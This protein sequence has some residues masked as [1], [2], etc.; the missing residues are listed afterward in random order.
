LTTG[1]K[2]DEQAI[3]KRLAR[4]P[5]MDNQRAYGQLPEEVE[6]GGTHPEIGVGDL[7]SGVWSE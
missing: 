5:P 6:K 4:L 1:G 3:R 2:T 7:P